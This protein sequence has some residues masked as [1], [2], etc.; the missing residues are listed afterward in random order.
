MGQVGGGQSPG[1]AARWREGTGEGL[2]VSIASRCIVQ[3]SRWG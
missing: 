2:G 3:G 1:D